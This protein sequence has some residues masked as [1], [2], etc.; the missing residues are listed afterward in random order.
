MRQVQQFSSKEEKDRALVSWAADV[1]RAIKDLQAVHFLDGIRL[2]DVTID[3]TDTLIP[4]KL[5]R[6]PRGFFWINPSADTTMWQ[7]V[8][9]N[10]TH[11]H[12]Q[13]TSA[14]VVADIWVF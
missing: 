6:T 4:H 11:I 9:P 10:S 5:G 2:N 13:V 8:A 12:L 1:V 7:P 14:A 3:V